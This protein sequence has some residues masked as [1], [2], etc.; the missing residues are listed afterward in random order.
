MKMIEFLVGLLVA[1]A[2]FGGGFLAGTSK[3]KKKSEAEILEILTEAQ[4]VRL[5]MLSKIDSL[6][7]LPAKID[8]VIFEVEK[9]IEKTDTLILTSKEILLNTDTLKSELREF[10]HEFERNR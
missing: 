8:T 6:Q 3:Q 5:E 7:N 2:S 10:R 9:I 1:V 4:I